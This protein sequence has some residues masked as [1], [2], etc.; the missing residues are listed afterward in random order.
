MHRAHITFNYLICKERKH[1]DSW[2]ENE[3]LVP[4]P[5]FVP[6][7]IENNNIQGFQLITDTT[8]PNN[9]PN[10]PNDSGVVVALKVAECL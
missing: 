6:N 7:K 4:F 5:C 3:H 9:N 10:I 2:C 8:E 1:E